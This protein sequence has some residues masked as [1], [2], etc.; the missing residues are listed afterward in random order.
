[1]CLGGRAAEDFSF[2]HY[3]PSFKVGA[4][5]MNVLSGQVL[6]W[7]G[8]INPHASP[9]IFA[10]REYRFPRDGRPRATWKMYIRAFSLKLEHNEYDRRK[11]VERVVHA[12]YDRVHWKKSRLSK[13]NIWL[14]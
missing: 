7:Y 2:S 10:F 3:A 8:S 1:M 6:S 13:P 5:K 12:C 11:N 9:R 4:H 14:K